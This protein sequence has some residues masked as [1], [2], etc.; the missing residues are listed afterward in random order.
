MAAINTGN[1]LYK[2]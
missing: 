2:N 1:D